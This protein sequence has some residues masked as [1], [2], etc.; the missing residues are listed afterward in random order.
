MNKLDRGPAEMA[1]WLRKHSLHKSIPSKVRREAVR[2]ANNLDA[3]ARH[4]AK[5]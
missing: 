1:T 4:K 2:A 5:K 3:V